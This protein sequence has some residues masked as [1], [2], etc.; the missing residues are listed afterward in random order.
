MRDV[1]NVS[2][3][4]LGNGNR[5]RKTNAAG[6]GLTRK[7]PCG[8]SE[9][10]NLEASPPIQTQANLQQTRAPRGNGAVGHLIRRTTQSIRTAHHA[11]SATNH[12]KQN[13]R[14]REGLRRLWMRLEEDVCCLGRGLDVGGGLRR[15]EGGGCVKRRGMSTSKSQGARVH[16]H[17]FAIST[18]NRSVTHDD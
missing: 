10:A 17:V 3:I 9:L 16:A 12:I 15:L 14:T 5:N 6:T 7:R 2:W 13:E 18:D 1:A 4:M 11:A 8:A